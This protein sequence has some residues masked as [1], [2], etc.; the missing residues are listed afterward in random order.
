VELQEKYG[1]QGLQVIGVAMDDASV[2]EITAF[3]RKMHVNYP[4]LKGT[5]QVATLY[6]GLEGLPTTFF[7]DRDGKVVDQAFGLES[8]SLME[9]AIKK[10]LGNGTTSTASVK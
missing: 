10:S 3:A 8:E 9:D 6:G 2:E 4:I 5:E 7:L 1:P